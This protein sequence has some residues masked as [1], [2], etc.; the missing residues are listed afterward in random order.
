MEEATAPNGECGF[1]HDCNA[2]YTV[3]PIQPDGIA[4][5]RGL[6]EA[7]IKQGIR[8][9]GAILDA[10][11]VRTDPEGPGGGRYTPYLRYSWVTPDQ[12]TGTY[13]PVRLF[14]SPG[15]KSYRHLDPLL[16]DLADWK[17]L[18][19]VLVLREGDPRI[20]SEFGIGQDP[21]AA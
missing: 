14:R 5:A 18:G 3:D 11:V 2:P 21:P 10:V 17:Y 13:G 19:G 20:L 6:P 9:G 4:V 12:A 1:R 15:I 7:S 8:E 16:G